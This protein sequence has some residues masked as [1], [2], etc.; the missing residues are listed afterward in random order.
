MDEQLLMY[1]CVA[2][3]V[4]AAAFFLM[5]FFVGGKD[6]KL[7]A[8]LNE[9]I[10]LGDAES[11]H[12]EQPER[13]AATQVLHRLG[14]AAAQPFAPSREKQSKLRRQLG[15]AGVYSPGAVN[16]VQG[17]KVIFMVGGLVVG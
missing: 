5:R 10:Q 2:G 16:L 12:M 1:V 4:S 8:R 11:Q 14:T 7:R 15:F 13:S 9:S 17:A 3:A 6:S